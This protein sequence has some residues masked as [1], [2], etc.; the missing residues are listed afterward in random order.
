MI[1]GLYVVAIAVG[2]VV[3]LL[4]TSGTPRSSERVIEIPLLYLLVIG[5][6]AAGLLA[7]VGH[8][9]YAA[10][11]ARNIGWPPGSPFQFEVAVADLSY[12]VLGLMCLHWRGPFWLATGVVTSIIFLGCNYGHLYDAW[13]NNNYAPDNYGIINLFEI[14]WPAA[15]LSLL[16]PYMRSWTRRHQVA[17]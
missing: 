14:V 4:Y 12:G 13:V 2:T 7:F 9:F 6:G 1:F 15:V 16:V 11:T 8:A 5:A 10:E 3:H 17:A